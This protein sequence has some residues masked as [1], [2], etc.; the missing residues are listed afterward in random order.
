MNQTALAPFYQVNEQAS[1]TAPK[2]FIA[3][4]LHA[5]IRKRKRDLGVIICSVPASAAAV[6]TTNA[7]QAAP[8][9]VTQENIGVDGKL[10]AIVVNS[11][12]ANSCTGERGIQDARDIA[13]QTAQLLDIP[14][15]QVAVASTGVIGQ[16]LPMEKIQTSLM[17]V[18]SI[19]DETGGN[20]FAE[21]I[22]TTDTLTKQVQ[23]TMQID[24]KKLTIAGVA[25]GS[26]MIHPNM[27]TMLGFITTDAVI[28]AHHLQSLL[29]T[30]TDSTF[31]MITVDGDCSTNDSVIAMAS[32]LAGN[33]SLHPHHPDWM[34]F[35]AGF[36]Y[37]CQE[38]AK[39]IANDGEGA[40]RLIEVHVAGAPTIEMARKVSKAIVGSNLVKSAVFGADANWGRILCAAGYGD[41]LIRTEKVKVKLGSILVVDK[42]LPVFFDESKVSE[43][44]KQETVNIFVDLQQGKQKATAWGCDLT[45]EYVKIN[46]SYRT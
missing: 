8:L 32:G 31:N 22:L 30:A 18:L 28:H 33:N 2:G 13:K 29:W 11:G 20:E 10:Q 15:H 5:G 34:A 12:V 44:L 7:F 17:K 21:A 40:T 9:Q 19:A 37:V 6:Y 36:T 16:F 14:I 41:P 38:L 39:K 4:G 24:G 25:K 43:I 35:Q 23:V 42:G 26:G 45:Y 3:T 1:I 27:A 46:A